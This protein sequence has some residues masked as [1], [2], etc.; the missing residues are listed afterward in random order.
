MASSPPNSADALLALLPP[1]TNKYPYRSLRNFR[2]IL[3]YEAKRVHEEPKSSQFVLFTHLTPVAF[4][5]DFK[6]PTRDIICHAIDSYSPKQEELVLKMKTGA[7][8]AAHKS[9]DKL[10]NEK[11]AFMNLAD[12]KLLGVGSKTVHASSRSKEAD[13]AYRPLD[14]PSG[15]TVD[16]PTLA[17]ESGY[18]ESAETLRNNAIW[19]LTAS[20]GDVKIVVTIDIN[21]R[22]RQVSFTKHD[23][24]N[25]DGSIQEQLVTVTPAGVSGCP[26]VLAFD[27]LL[28][29]HPT[30][31]ESDIEFTR[32]DFEYMA[33]SIWREQFR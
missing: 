28:L 21:K 19:W 14:L 12:R 5:S 6:Q 20:A 7:H 10:L 18:T 26:M 22:N 23:H 29:T 17:M 24:L 33:E 16:W 9:F 27:R 25:D 31:A 4:D 2:S 8:E 30:A 32:A 11:L 3:S 1:Y 13:Q 15:R